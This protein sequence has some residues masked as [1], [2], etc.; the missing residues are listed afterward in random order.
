[1]RLTSRAVLRR[2]VSIVVALLAVAV[3]AGCGRTVSTDV[4]GGVL[5]VYS[6]SALTGPQAKTG[7]ALVTG[8]KLALGLRRGAVGDLLVKYVSL[9]SARGAASGFDPTVVTDN[10]QNVVDDSSAI[11]Y[12]GDAAPRATRVSLPILSAAQIAILSPTDPDG[13]LTAPAGGRPGDAYIRGVRTGYSLAPL[14]DAQIWALAGPRFRAEFRHAFGS[15]PNAQAAR[16]FVAMN[17]VL[18]AVKAAGRQG[19]DRHGVTT[20]LGPVVQRALR[21]S[22]NEV[23]VPGVPPVGASSVH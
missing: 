2:R 3:I 12:L 10:A 7:E 4:R 1:V 16:G 22:T 8:E 23:P 17:L 20:A 21:Q 5:T 9:D 6:A 15:A 11:A 13:T 14:R 18:D 19:G